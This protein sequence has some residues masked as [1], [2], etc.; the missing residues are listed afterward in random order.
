MKISQLILV[1]AIAASGYA[2]KAF[3]FGHDVKPVKYTTTTSLGPPKT[4]ITKR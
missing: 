4:N 1:L 3:E 2:R